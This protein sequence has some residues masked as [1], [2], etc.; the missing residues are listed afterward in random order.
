MFSSSDYDSLL[1][2]DEGSQPVASSSSSSQGIYPPNHP[3]RE[4]LSG[5]IDSL[6]T[7][8]YK[9][10]PSEQGTHTSGSLDKTIMESSRG[11]PSTSTS[12]QEDCRLSKANGAGKMPQPDAILHPLSGP[13]VEVCQAVGKGPKKEHEHLMAGSSSPLPPSPQCV[14]CLEAF[15]SG[16]VVMT[17]PCIHQFHELCITPYMTQKGSRAVCPV[18]KTPVFL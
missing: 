18:C 7:F 11:K 2:L 5:L 15:S 3:Q 4:S 10:K 6:P 16:Q 8:I 17:L 13:L 1:S 14:I 9:S 12:S